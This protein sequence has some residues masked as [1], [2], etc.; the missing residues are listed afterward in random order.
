MRKLIAPKYL[1]NDV[2]RKV[3]KI[4]DPNILQKFGNVDK[5]GN[6]TNV[7]DEAR[8]DPK[9]NENEFYIHNARD[10]ENARQ[11]IHALIGESR[12]KGVSAPEH[13]ND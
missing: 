8:Y 9:T 1:I 7:P 13:K 11:V 10:P 12:G 2:T 4:G 3:F 6:L 5:L